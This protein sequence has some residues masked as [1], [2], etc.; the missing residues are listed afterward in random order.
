MFISERYQPRRI[1]ASGV[2]TRAGKAFKVYE[3]NVAGQQVCQQ[4]FERGID[5]GLTQLADK[6]SFE[7]ATPG[8]MIKH[9][10]QR[11]DYLIMA[12]WGNEN[13]CFIAVF[14]GDERQQSWRAAVDESFCIWDL[15]VI[16]AERNHFV[17]HILSSQGEVDT[18][19]YLA[20]FSPFDHV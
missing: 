10:G 2:Q 11:Y 4:A 6:T 3:I 12:W 18:A 7:H 19:P 20:D 13:E 8:F 15:Q 1:I 17:N 5:F 9:A 16:H 14:I